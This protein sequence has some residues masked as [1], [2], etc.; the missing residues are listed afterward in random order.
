MNGVNRVTLL[1]NVGRDPELRTTQSGT[2]VCNFTVATNETWKDRSGNTESKTEWHNIVVWKSLA[3]VC[4]EYLRR[5]SPVY[6]EGKL[7]TREYEQDG[8]KRRIT[9]IVAT[10]VH[11]L[12][13]GNGGNS[14]DGEHAN[15][16]S[17]GYKPKSVDD[18]PF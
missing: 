17:Q 13:G 18:L 10:E 6:L 5:G 15:A 11:F 12:G 16:G 7:Q 14:G 2:S 4:S 9:E 3:N 1:G 8:I